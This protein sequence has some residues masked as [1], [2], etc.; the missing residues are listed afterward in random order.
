MKFVGYFEELEPTMPR[1]VS[2]RRVVGKLDA[3]LAGALA[4]YL[5]SGALVAAVPLAA[6]DVLSLDRKPTPA[7]HVLTDGEYVW[8][9]DLAYYVET[10]LVG[11]PRRFTRHAE[12]S[13]YK[14]DIDANAV[15]RVEAELRG[16]K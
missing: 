2:M 3:N 7:P 1:K 16:Q 12:L 4:G 6:F 10:Y 8:R 14:V 15:R 11:L 9:G 13:G 5:R